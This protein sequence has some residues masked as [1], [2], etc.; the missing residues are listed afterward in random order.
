MA[1]GWA[2]EDKDYQPN[3]YIYASDIN[4]MISLFK[5]FIVFDD[6]NEFAGIQI[7]T[8]GLT[9]YATKNNKSVKYLLT[10][11]ENGILQTEQL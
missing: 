8:S 7:P 9:L 11:D 5:S 6:K 2:K 4:K 1:N 10:I 3:D